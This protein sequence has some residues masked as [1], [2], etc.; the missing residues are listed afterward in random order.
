MIFTRVKPGLKL[1]IDP[2]I[3]G[4]ASQAVLFQIDQKVSSD[5]TIVITDDRQIQKLNKKFRGID[6]VTDVLSFPSDQVDPE[7]GIEYLGDIIIS[8]PR[9]V[10]QAA[11]AG[12]LVET[13]LQV[14]IVHGTL[15]LLGFDHDNIMEKD[16]MWNAQEMIFKNLG[17]P[18][19]KLTE[20][21][22]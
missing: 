22:I 8:Y 6:S 20:A 15:H 1:S 12:H 10:D 5:L 11:R 18:N 16:K 17:I 7:S 14:L 21:E 3:L 9:A 19:V 4:N 2:S 13:E